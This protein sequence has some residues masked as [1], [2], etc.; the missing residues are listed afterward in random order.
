MRWSDL[1]LL[2]DLGFSIYEKK[3]LAA[4]SL[5]GVA[6]AATLCREG[7]IPTSKIYRAMEKLGE[8]GVVEV[9]PTRPK[10]YAALPADAVVDRLVELARARADRFA[11]DSRALR[12]L[13]RGVA[14]KV[15]GR[16]AFADLAIGVESHGKRHLARLAS[17]ERRIL[18]YLE[19]GDLDAFD[20]LEK[21]R[22]RVLRRISR[23][24]R[25]QGV[26]HRVVFGFRRRTASALNDFLR[27]HGPEL[28]HVTGVRYSG[29]LGHPFHV[30]DDDTVI[31]SLDHPFVPEGR[32]ASLLVRDRELADKLAAGFE[33]LFAKAMR[34]LREIRFHPEGT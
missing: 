9:Q 4:V 20:R 3:A 19:Q 31:L 5:L 6:D 7:D 17:A 10:L 12:E 2:D 28:A 33:E 29:E 25:E 13:L 32:F 24:V 11:E 23:H 14:E 21:K 16:H 30:I 18:S 34:D 8:L 15:P 26:D 22:F 1:A 27:R